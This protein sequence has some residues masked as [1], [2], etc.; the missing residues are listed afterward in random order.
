LEESA[1][2]TKHI[3]IVDDQPQIRS[4][5]QEALLD[6]GHEPEQAADG[7]EALAMLQNDHFDLVISDVEMPVMSGIEL[8]SAV[9]KSAD[10][11][12]VILMSGKSWRRPNGDGAT[13]APIQF[14]EKPFTLK[15][16]IRLINWVL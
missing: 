5:L 8:L 7:R 13:P 6:L 9:R 16:I 1:A 11:V 3:L 15:R 12:P 14:I 4:L 10:P 2:V